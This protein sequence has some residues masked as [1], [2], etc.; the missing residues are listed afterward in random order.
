M[1]SLLQRLFSQTF[2]DI[3]F[4][5]FFGHVQGD[6]QIAAFN[7]EIESSC[8]ILN[9]VQC[10]FGIS[11]L[12]EVSNDALSDQVRVSNDLQDFIVVLLDK[13]ELEAVLRGIDL[14]GS[15]SGGPVQ[16][17][18][19]RPLDSSQV[20][21]LLQRLD[22]SVVAGFVERFQRTSYLT[23]A[24]NIPLEQSIF[25]MIQGGVD[26]DTAVIPCSRLDADGLVDERALRKRLVG[27][28][29]S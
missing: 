21:R 28:G 15:R 14:N 19:G 27:D 18:N 10:N 2:P 26:E 13:G 25:D 20:N 4:V 6:G 7:G 11:F 24:R 1:I 9:E 3:S 8:G 29:N 5:Q 22:D 12:L 17:V 16:A 23:V